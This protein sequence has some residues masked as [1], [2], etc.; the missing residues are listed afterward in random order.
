MCLFV[1]PDH[2][3]HP[4]LLEKLLL[5]LFLF[6]EFLFRREIMFLVDFFEQ[7]F[8]FFV[9]QRELRVNNLKALQ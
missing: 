3:R 8:E 6:F 7:G 2:F 5:L 4:V 9:F 1:V